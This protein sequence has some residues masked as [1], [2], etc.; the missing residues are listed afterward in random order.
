MCKSYKVLIL[1]AGSGGISVAARLSKSWGVARLRLS[2]RLIGISINP[3][4]RS[5]AQES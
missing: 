1:G 4:G 3:F 2:I 5:W